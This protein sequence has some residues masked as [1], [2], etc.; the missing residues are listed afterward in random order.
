MKLYMIRLENGNAAI[1]QAENEEAAIEQ[2]GL[3]VDP[4]AFAKEQGV[5]DVA[6][7][8]LELVR[9]GLGP[10]NF[11]IRELKDFFCLV[12]LRDD[13]RFQFALESQETDEEFYEDYPVLWSAEDP[14]LQ[15]IDPFHPEWNKRREPLIAEAV[16]R[17]RTRLL[18]VDASTS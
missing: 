15:E 9:S 7:Q 3:R 8:H 5:S 18:V 4:K 17:E 6:A 13:G 1:L 14:L 16:E 12:S 11:R 2:A 10:Q